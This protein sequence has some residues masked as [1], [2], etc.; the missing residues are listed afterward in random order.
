MHSV[1]IDCR[2]I[3]T[4][5]GVC[6][7]LASCGCGR[8]PQV[9][10]GTAEGKVLLDGVPVTQGTIIF[11]NASRGVARLAEIQSDGTFTQRSIGFAG[12]PVGNKTPQQSPIPAGYHRP[13]TS[14]LSAE[15]SAGKNAPFKFSLS[16]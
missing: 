8:K 16:R 7:A 10:W 13:E 14:G 6:L 4:I 3:R 9:P 15:V 11:D 12:V 5:A 2:R 1:L